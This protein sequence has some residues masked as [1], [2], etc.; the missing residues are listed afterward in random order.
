MYSVSTGGHVPIIDPTHYVFVTN[1]DGRA[2]GYVYCIHYFYQCTVLEPEPQHY[3]LEPKWKFLSRC[4]TNIDR[5][6]NIDFD[7][8]PAPILWLIL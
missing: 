8:A 5:L 3:M 2:E 1:S 4:R 7:M 6:C